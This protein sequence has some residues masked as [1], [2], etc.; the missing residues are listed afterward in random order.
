MCLEVKRCVEVGQPQPS[1][2]PGAFSTD[3]VQ[4]FFGAALSR[5]IHTLASKE[6]RQGKSMNVLDK[7]KL[8][9]FRA[10][11]VENDEKEVAGLPPSL[12]LRDRGWMSF[13]KPSFLEFAENTMQVIFA[14]V[15]RD[16]YEKYGEQL[17]KQATT[18]LECDRSVVEMFKEAV[19]ISVS[20]Q[21]SDGVIVSCAQAMSLKVLRAVVEEVIDSQEQIQVQAAGSTST[22]W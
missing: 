4:R 18:S 22:T 17:I 15:N 13:L 20:T 12:M 16:T 19:Q 3:H 14:L 21:F 8:D 11:R 9:L 5:C 6:K 2:K 7:Q 10:V 1:A